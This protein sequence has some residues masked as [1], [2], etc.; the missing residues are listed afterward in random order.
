MKPNI[1]YVN[2][3]YVLANNATLSCV[4]QDT[5]ELQ[6]LS[7]IIDSDK[8]VLDY[9]WGDVSLPSL[10][11]LYNMAKAAGIEWKKCKNMI[12]YG[13]FDRHKL[14]HPSEYS[15]IEENMTLE[16]ERKK[17]PF[18]GYSDRPTIHMSEGVQG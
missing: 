7:P 3:N 1:F 12:A 15:F 6:I 9:C 13:I 4:G 11:A 8:I 14:S 18:Q 2:G 16:G 10:I 5:G 17:H